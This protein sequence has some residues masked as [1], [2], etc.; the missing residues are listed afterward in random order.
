MLAVA[1]RARPAGAV[2]Q[3]AGSDSPTETKSLTSSLKMQISVNYFPLLLLMC[4]GDIG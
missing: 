2:E 3:H 1:S 4:W